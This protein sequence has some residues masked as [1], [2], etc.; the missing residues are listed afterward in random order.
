MQNKKGNGQLQEILRFLVTGI[1]CFAI[2]FLILVMLKELAHMD[3][4]LATPISFLAAVSANYLICVAWV[5]EGS[6]TSER[7]AKIGFLITS[8]I[9]LVLNEVF[10]LSFRLLWG[11]DAVL[12]PIFGISISL[13]M[14]N[15]AI[16]TLLVM[17]WNY[18][19]KRTLLCNGF[20]MNRK[21]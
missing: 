14:L 12:L 6:K 1:V 13:Y 11:E 9:G 5:F 21:N 4:L 3:T 10:M 17:I 19:T 15:K 18:F 2:E 16:A 20:S 8:I 7:S